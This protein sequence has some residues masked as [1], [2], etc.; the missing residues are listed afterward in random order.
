M[1]SAR[2]LWDALRADLDTLG[3]G[4]SL[5][6][7]VGVDALDEGLSA[8]TLAHVFN[9]DVDALGDDAGVDALVH[10]NT[11]GVLGHIEDASGFAVVELVRK[12]GLHATITDNI[13]VI[14]LF[15]VGKQPGKWSSSVAS[16]RLGEQVSCFTPLT[17]V[18]RH[19]SF[20]LPII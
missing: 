16:E 5:L 17:F 18:V 11:D 2:L 12:T 8:L 19:L 4:L 3:L 7:V 10:D 9:A 6:G 20:N 13:N 14:S 1:S 15:V